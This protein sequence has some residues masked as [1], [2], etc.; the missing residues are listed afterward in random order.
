MRRL[1]QQDLNLDQLVTVVVQGRITHPRARPEAYRI[2]NAGQLRVWPS[3]GGIVLSHRVGDRC[4]GL[5]GDHIEPGVS[6][7]H[8]P[9]VRSNNTPQNLA[10]MTYSC[11]GNLALVT[12]GPAR[13]ARG[14]VTGKHGGVNHVIIDFPRKVLT[15]LRIGDPIK[16]ISRG[17]GLQLND[18]D[19]IRLSNLSPSLMNAW[20]LGITNSQL[21]VPIRH[22]VPGRLLGS[23]LGKN[24]VWRGDVDIQLADNTEQTDRLRLLRFGDFVALMD[25]DARYGPVRRRGWTTIGVVIHGDSVVSG[26]GPGVTVLMTGPASVFQLTPTSDANLA[27]RLKLRPVGTVAYNSVQRRRQIYQES[28]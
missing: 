3:T 7:Q 17:Q 2:G 28:A 15:R 4:V 20:R 13:G 27:D 16:I 18:F 8:A 24:T 25:V 19:T 9:G 12:D 26:H 14:V 10:L 1:Q 11:V 5:Q 22:R 23:G 6:I 21:V